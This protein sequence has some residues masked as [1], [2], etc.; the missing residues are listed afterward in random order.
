MGLWPLPLAVGVSDAQFNQDGRK[1]LQRPQRYKNFSS[2]SKVGGAS[3]ECRC[4][5]RVLTDLSLISHLFANVFSHFLMKVLTAAG[6]S[7]GEARHK[8]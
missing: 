1:A 4:C 8:I 6:R 2:E 3:E 7:E 5:P